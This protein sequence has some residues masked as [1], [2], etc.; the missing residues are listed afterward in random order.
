LHHR[1]AVDF[2]LCAADVDAPG[3]VETAGLVCFFFQ[4][5]VNLE[6]VAVNFSRGIGTGDGE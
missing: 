3:V 1:V 5:A 2:V 4:F 6:G